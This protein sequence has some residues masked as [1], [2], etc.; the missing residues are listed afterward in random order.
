MAE[1]SI[2][3][4]WLALCGV[5]AYIAGGKGRSEVGIFFLSFFMSPLVGIIV[6]LAISPNLAAQGKKKC[7]SCA[8]FVQPDARVCRFCQ[9]SFVEEEA[10][11]QAR[12]KAEHASARALQQAEL[13]AQQT[14]EAEKPWLQRNAEPLFVVSLTAA[15]MIGSAWYGATRPTE[16][17]TLMPATGIAPESRPA[18][19]ARIAEERSRV[20]KTVWDKRVAWAA[21][22]HCYFAAMSRDELLRAL[23]RP[24]SETSSDLVYN[25]RTNEC[26]RYS[27]DM[28]SEYKADEQ[29][30]LLKDGY[31]DDQLDVGG[32]CRTL[33]GENQNLGLEMPDFRLSTAKVSKRTARTAEEAAWHTRTAG[34]AASWHTKENC[35]ADGFFWKEESPTQERGCF[36]K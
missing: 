19:P 15:A 21:Q 14:A 18:M 24:T 8:E 30:I 31:A 9:H 10:A 11:E 16:Q 35:E 29:T 17:N 25:H 26:A 32:G 33:Y 28:C 13:A 23:G 3:V 34:E 36:L 5:A 2:F 4:I 22:H 7:P 12:I 6:A 1:L 20:P 27:G